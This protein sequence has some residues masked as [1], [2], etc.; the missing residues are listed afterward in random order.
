ML[1]MRKTQEPYTLCESGEDDMLDAKLPLLQSDSGV[2][3]QKCLRWV[4][5]SQPKSLQFGVRSRPQ[6]STPL[7]N[8]TLWKFNRKETGENHYSHAIK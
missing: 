1:L 3:V 5:Q 6:R 2:S 4:F 8:G 7:A